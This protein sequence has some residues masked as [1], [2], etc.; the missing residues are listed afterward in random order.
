MPGLLLPLLLADLLLACLGYKPKRPHPDIPVLFL[1]IDNTL[2][3]PNS[4]ISFLMGRNID[5]YFRKHLTHMTDLERN[6][7]HSQ[8]FMEYGLSVR[9]LILHHQVDPYDFEREVDSC[10]PL[11]HLIFPDERLRRMLLHCKGPRL[12]AFTNAGLYHASRVL[13]ILGIQDLIEGI[14]WCDYGAPENE[15]TCKPDPKSFEKAMKEAGQPDP[16]KCFLVD[17]SPK[18]CTA[19]MTLDWAGSIYVMHD[20]ERDQGVGT[21]QIRS[22]YDLPRA[23]P[24]FWVG[25]KTET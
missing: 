15:W 10:L 5:C 12:W 16:S 24:Q 4:G 9:G 11:E 20:K 21:A 18:N 17:D 22:I 6:R 13:H 23:L 14:T 8:Y 7:L 25:S 2:Y 1:D 19:A 3:H